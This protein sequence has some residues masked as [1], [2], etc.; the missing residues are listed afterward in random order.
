MG[1]HPADLLTDA[2]QK[3][4][5]KMQV[6]QILAIQ[7][8]SDIQQITAISDL[9]SVWSARC[10]IN[11]NAIKPGQQTWNAIHAQNIF[12]KATLGT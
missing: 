2:S 4:R 10:C 6:R 8:V 9:L 3:I 1:G 5:F 12:C 7:C 11:M